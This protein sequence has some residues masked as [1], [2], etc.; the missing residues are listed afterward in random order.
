MSMYSGFGL[1]TWLFSKNNSTD[2][3]KK[4]KYLYRENSGKKELPLELVGKCVSINR[5]NQEY[6]RI[7]MIAEQEFGNR[8]IDNE[9]MVVDIPESYVNWC[10]GDKNHNVVNKCFRYTDKDTG[11]L[12]VRAPLIVYDMVILDTKC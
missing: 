4:E 2:I 9:F 7:T 11:R 3:V 8:Y 5:N 1:Y 10:S 12:M 6:L